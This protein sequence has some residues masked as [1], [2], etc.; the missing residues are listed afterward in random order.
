MKRGRRI[1]SAFAETYSIVF[2]LATSP[3]GMKITFE[4]VFRSF[5]GPA[6]HLAN[7]V[8]SA[9]KVL[10]TYFLEEIRCAELTGATAFHERTPGRHADSV[11]QSSA[12]CEA[13]MRGQGGL[14]EWPRLR[15]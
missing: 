4:K 13:G 15:P 6:S 5:H 8:G 14:I 1:G 2:L 3:C 12:E 10:L 11:L 7:S 9:S